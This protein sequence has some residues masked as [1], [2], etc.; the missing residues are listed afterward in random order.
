[1][2]IVLVYSILK[3]QGGPFTY[4]ICMMVTHY[5][6]HDGGL[7]TFCRVDHL[8]CDPTAHQGGDVLH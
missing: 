6:A 7:I 3:F 4:C 1:M 2:M 5:H 8:M